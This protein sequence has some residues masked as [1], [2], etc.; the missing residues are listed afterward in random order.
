MVIL[1]NHSLGQQTMMEKT[2]NL[3]QRHAQVHYYEQGTGE[4]TVLLIHG[5]CINAGYWQAQLA[6]LASKGYRA[7]SLDLPGFGKSTAQRSQ[8]SI[9]SYAQDLDAFI[10]ALQLQNVVLVAHSMAGDIMLQLASKANT[11][12]KG[13]VGIDNFK[14][15][16]VEFTPEQYQEMSKYMNLFETDFKN[17]SQTYAEYALFHPKTSQEVKNQVKQDFSQSNPTV[18]LSAFKNMIQFASGVNAKLETLSRKLY[19]I[20]NST[21]PTNEQGLRNRC[22]QGFEVSYI[23]DSGHYPMIEK[24]VEFNQLLE[25]VLDNIQ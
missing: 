7:I 5:W 11:A 13:L 8:W 23:S 12:I 6:F 14:F 25:K 17:A 16:E 4:K 2:I 24:P 3:K 21:L 15:V 20:N 9:E 1:F 10:K 19:L 18:A 22:K